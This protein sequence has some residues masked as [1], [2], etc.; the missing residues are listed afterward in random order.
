MEPQ[1]SLQ[2]A[3]V[4]GTTRILGETGKVEQ[5][6]KRKFCLE[7]SP[8]CRG[9]IRCSVGQ[10]AARMGTFKSQMQIHTALHPNLR[11]LILLIRKTPFKK[12]G[13]SS[14]LPEGSFS[15]CICQGSRLGVPWPSHRVP[16]PWHIGRA[17]HWD[18]G[19]ARQEGRSCGCS[20]FPSEAQNQT[21]SYS[22]VSFSLPCSVDQFSFGSFPK[23]TALLL[24]GWSCSSH[25]KGIQAPN[26][27]FHGSQEA[28]STHHSHQLSLEPEALPSLSVGKEK[29]AT[30]IRR[31]LGKIK[32]SALQEQLRNTQTLPDL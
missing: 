13:L 8:P 21:Q 1:N 5:K 7:R 20:D 24:T 25:P 27:P 22:G 29:V 28:L 10:E 12:L 32:G 9:K 16:G 18:G 11:G 26:H 3:L 17:P 31:N 4:Q 19:A 15:L 23:N 30:K 2:Y 6:G 14:V